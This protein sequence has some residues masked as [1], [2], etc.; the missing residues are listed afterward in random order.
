MQ[1]PALVGSPSMAD[2]RDAA[3]R[4][5]LDLRVRRAVPDETL[6]A[7]LPA[8]ALLAGSPGS[9]GQFIVL[10]SAGEEGVT[11]IDAA[12]CRLVEAP[13]D[14]FLARWTGHLLEP[15][16]PA[17]PPWM[18]ALLLAAA[19]GVATVLVLSGAQ[20]WTS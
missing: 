4:Q 9:A 12:T 13:W 1:H 19:G 2:L 17:D 7:R 10:V 14:E 20:R 18:R 11:W 6:D 3:G 16:G 15:E 5:G 8:L